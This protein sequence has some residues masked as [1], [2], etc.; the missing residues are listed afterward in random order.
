MAEGYSDKR[1]VVIVAGGSGKRMGE[2]LPKQFRIIGTT[3]VLGMTINLFARAIKGIEIVV[4]LPEERI[5][6]WKNLSARFDIAKHKCVAGGMERFHSVRRGIEALAPSIDL[7]AVHDGVRPLASEELIRRCFECAATHDSAVPAIAPPDS[8]RVVRDGDSYPIDRSSL[9]IIQTPQIFRGDLL[10][11][12]YEQEYES[13]FTDDSS[14]VENMLHRA[15][16][17]N[18]TL[19][20][21]ERTNIK[22]TTPDDFTIAEAIIS[23]RDGAES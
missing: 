11:Q 23:Q 3:P 5:D 4:V 21:G 7:I 8:Y 19:C 17:G 6:F 2:G 13:W 1:G 18:I 15:N 20:E 12:A 9:R 16:R 22:L 14:V 10:R